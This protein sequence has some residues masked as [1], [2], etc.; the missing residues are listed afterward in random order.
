MVPYP[1]R[2]DLGTDHTV[3]EMSDRDWAWSTSLFDNLNYSGRALHF[4]RTPLPLDKDG[5]AINGAVYKAMEG[6][7]FYYVAEC[8]GRPAA[9]VRFPL[10]CCRRASR[11]GCRLWVVC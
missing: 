6:K 8:D 4:L 5:E 10:T 11:V 9:K 7:G 2:V 3:Y 1:N